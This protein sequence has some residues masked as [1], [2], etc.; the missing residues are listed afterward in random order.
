MKVHFPK[1]YAYTIEN[2]YRVSVSA[3]EASPV[4]TCCK[5]DCCTKGLYIEDIATGNVMVG[6][7][8]NGAWVTG[9]VAQFDAARALYA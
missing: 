3:I 2:G 4:N 5:L 1:G 6:W 9:T 8:E 7:F